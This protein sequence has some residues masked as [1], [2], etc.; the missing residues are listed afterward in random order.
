MNHSLSKPKLLLDENFEPRIYLPKLNRLYD[1]KHVAEDLHK[2][3][4]EDRKV[5]EIAVKQERIVV[6]YNEKDFRSFAH[7]SEKS[8]VIGIST[9]LTPTQI[10]TKLAALLKK[11]SSKSLYGAFHYISGETTF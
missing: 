11:T 4:I 10:D 5:Y 1:I 7:V 2:G 3:G 6:T 9:N 8:G